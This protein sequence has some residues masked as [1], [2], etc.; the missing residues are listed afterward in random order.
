MHLKKLSLFNFKN[1]AGKDF[2]F[3]TKINC[4]V[5]NNGVGKTN[6]L[7]AI[8][9]LSFGKSYFN[10]NIRQII[11]FDEQAF[12]IKGEFE[13]N[14]KNDVILLSYQIDKKKVLKRNNKTYD[15]LADHI[16]LIPLVMISPYDRDLISESGETRRKF[17]DRIISQ[18]DANY[19]SALI[20][21]Q[22]VLA[23]RNRLLKYFAA[24]HRFDRETLDIYNQQLHQYGTVIFNKRQDFIKDFADFLKEKY[25][26]LSQGK[27]AVNISYYSELEI[28][29]LINLLEENIQKD[30][31]LQHTSKGIHRDDFLFEIN[32][33]PIRKFGSQGQQKSFLIAL[34]L[35]EFEFLK[36]RSSQTPILLFDDIFDKLDETRVEQIVKMVNQKTFGQI[37]ITDTHAERTENLV[38]NIHQSFKVFN[39]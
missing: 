1:F 34:R 35:A 32:E 4:F 36:H 30:R 29:P 31:I 12:S 39:L 15:R 2:E 6:I 22:K 20:S 17:I 11:K 9:F 18:A 7:D 27:E 37:F 24:N 26:V 33:K 25:A 13:I 21:Y 5:G 38:K 19:L 10:N 8:Y 23:Q 28:K 16:G 3:D 14:Q